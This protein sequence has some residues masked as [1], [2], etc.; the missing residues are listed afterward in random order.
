VVTFNSFFSQ[1]MV[2]FFF[3]FSKIPLLELAAFPLLLPGE[4][5]SSPKK[6]KKKTTLVLPGPVQSATGGGWPPPAS[7]A[8]NCM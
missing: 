8:L 3:K 1:G 2:N 7:E 5:N 6:K 4:E